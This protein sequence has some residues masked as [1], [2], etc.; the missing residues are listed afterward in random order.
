MDDD[1][2]SVLDSLET[3]RHQRDSGYFTQNSRS[4]YETPHRVSSRQRFQAY[5][6]HTSQLARAG[7]AGTQDDYEFDKFDDGISFD[8]FGGCYGFIQVSHRD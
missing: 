1:I 2:F 3:Q 5:E 6:P 7:N 8:D 4:S